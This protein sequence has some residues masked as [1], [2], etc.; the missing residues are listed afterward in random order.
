MKKFFVVMFVALAG[1]CASAQQ[2]KLSIGADL[3]IAPVLE[4]IGGTNFEIGA[5]VRYGLTDNVRL[6]GNID[7]AFKASYVDMFDITANVHYVVPVSS[8]V[9]VYPLAGIGYGHSSIS[10]SSHVGGVDFKISQGY[11]R[12]LFNIGAGADFQI[13]DGVCLNFE[14]KYQYFKDF[15]RLPIKVGIVFDI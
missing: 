13:G 7:Y 2:G 9:A 4:D 15:S 6:E 11:N 8:K 14:L 3:G 1:L 12:F 10:S 5:K